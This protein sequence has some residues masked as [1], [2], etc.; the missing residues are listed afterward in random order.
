MDMQTLK[1]LIEALR[2]AG[3]GDTARSLLGPSAETQLPLK[4]GPVPTYNNQGQGQG[5]VQNAAQAVDPQSREAQI[6]AA[7]AAAGG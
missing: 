2:S 1:L 4:G 5:A 3:P 6:R 7:L